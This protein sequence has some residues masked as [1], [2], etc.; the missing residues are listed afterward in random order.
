MTC[1]SNSR[2][3]HYVDKEIILPCYE[4]LCPFGLAPTISTEVQ[5]LFGDVLAIALMEQK[6][7]TIDAYANNHPAGQIGKRSTLKVRDIMLTKERAPLCLPHHKLDEVL[8]DFTEKR[9]GCL[10]VTNEAGELEG[11]FTD[12]DLRRALQAQG[13]SVLQECIGALMTVYPKTILPDALA[14]EAMRLME[15][16]RNAPIT[17]LPVIDPQK[18]CVLGIVKMH[19]IIQ[20]GI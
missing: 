3:S 9:C 1:T 7:F 2:L 16:D 13:E 15:A 11:I 19:D 20:A 6:S 10:I 12:G 8:P 17:V 14:W 18:H 5:L 4:E